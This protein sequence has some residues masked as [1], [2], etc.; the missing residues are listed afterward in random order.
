MIVPEFK[1]V[2]MVSLTIGNKEFTWPVTEEDYQMIMALAE[3]QFGMPAES[4]RFVIEFPDKPVAEGI[5]GQK[6]LS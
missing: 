3:S 4:F 1:L 6:T 5:V 2:R